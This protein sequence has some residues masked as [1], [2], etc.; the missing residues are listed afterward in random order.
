MKSVQTTT[1]ATKEQITALRAKLESILE[2]R[3]ISLDEMQEKDDHD[4][5]WDEIYTEACRSLGMNPKIGNWM[6]FGE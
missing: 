3:G 2:E 6:V 5:L 4:P 1:T